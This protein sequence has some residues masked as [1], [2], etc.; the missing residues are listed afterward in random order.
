MTDKNCPIC[1]GMRWICEN[2]PDK[3]WDEKLGCMCG[4]GIS[5]ECN[6]VDQAGLDE[7]RLEAGLRGEVVP[8]LVRSPPGVDD[9][10]RKLSS[11]GP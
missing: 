9:G 7:R 4:A 6:S 5:C 2:H 3:A 10:S 1:F 11:A 8:D